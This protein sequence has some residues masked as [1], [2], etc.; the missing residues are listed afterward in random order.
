MFESSVAYSKLVTLHPSLFHSLSP[1]FTHS[2]LYLYLPASFVSTKNSLI[3]LAIPST[4]P[5]P[6]TLTLPAFPISP[7]PTYILNGLLG[8]CCPCRY[9]FNRC[10]PISRGMKEIP[11]CLLARHLRMQGSSMLDGLRIVAI[12]E[13]RSVSVTLRLN[14][15]FFWLKCSVGKN[16]QILKLKALVNISQRTRK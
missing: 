6:D 16:E 8:M 5:L 13:L 2:L 1:P 7:S 12:R 10:S 9:T 11:R 3:S 15:T 14:I 4:R